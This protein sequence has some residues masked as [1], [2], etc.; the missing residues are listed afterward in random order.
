MRQLDA[1]QCIQLHAVL[2]QSWTLPVRS[3]ASA[4]RAL[5]ILLGVS[6]GLHIPI[7]RVPAFMGMYI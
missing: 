1:S 7:V 5:H 3:W 4:A 2:A 6:S